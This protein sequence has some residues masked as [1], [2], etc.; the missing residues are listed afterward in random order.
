M[1]LT[2]TPLAENNTDGKPVWIF[3]NMRGDALP[4]DANS[5]VNPYIASGQMYFNRQPGNA[6]YN[7]MRDY[8]YT[9]WAWNLSS[10]RHKYIIEWPTSDEVI[11]YYHKIVGG[12]EQLNDYSLNITGYVQPRWIEPIPSTIPAENIDLD[13]A[14]NT[15]TFIGPINM[16]EWSMNTWAVEDLIENWSMYGRLPRGIPYI[17]FEVVSDNTP[18]PVPVIVGPDLVKTGN[19]NSWNA[20]ASWALVGNIQDYEWDFGDGSLI[21]TDEEVNHIYTADGDY[22]ITLTVNDSEGNS[23]STTKMIKASTVIAPE[24]IITKPDGS[25]APAGAR[26]D[27]AVTL[28]GW[29]SF[30][31][32]GSITDWEWDFGDGSLPVSGTGHPQNTTHTYTTPGTYIVSLTLTDNATNIAT[33]TKDLRIAVNLSD[34]IAKF[35][36]P[37]MAVVNASVSL[38]AS[39]SLS[40]VGATITSYDWDFDDGGTATGVAT[41]H[42]WNTTGTHSATLTVT[43]DGSNVSTPVMAYIEIYSDADIGIGLSLETHALKPGE[44]TNLTITMVDMA[45][46]TL[47]TFAGVVDLSSAPS[48]GVTMPAT[49]TFI[50]AD[51][52]TKTLTGIIFANAGSYKITANYSGYEGYEFASVDNRTVEITVYDI[53]E[54]PLYSFWDDRGPS[55]N[56]DYRYEYAS[57]PYVHYYV[58]NTAKPLQRELYTTYR[59]GLDARN[60]PEISINNPTFLPNFAYYSPFIT[61]ISGITGGNATYDLYW[62]YLA[63]DRWEQLRTDGWVSSSSTNNDGWWCMSWSNLTMDRDAAARLMGIPLAWSQSDI[64]DWWDPAIG[65]YAGQYDVQDAWELYWWANETGT[66]TTP[67]RLDYSAMYDAIRIVDT[68]HDGS[69]AQAPY[70]LSVTGGGTQVVLS[71]FKASWGEDALLIRQ[72]YYGGENYGDVYPDGPLMGVLPTEGWLEDFHMTVDMRPTDA[73]VMLDTGIVYGWRA[74]E[75]ADA[76]TGTASWRWE[77]IE[78]DYLISNGATILESELDPY[79]TPTILTY[80]SLDCGSKAYGGEEVTYDFVPGIWIMEQGESLVIEAPDGVVIGYLPSELLGYDATH[81]FE[82]LDVIEKWGYAT[83]HASGL[84]SDEYTVDAASGDLKIVGPFTPPI[85]PHP[86]NPAVAMNPA[87]LIEIWV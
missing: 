42:T 48:A 82:T 7:T 30:D 28:G 8:D 9:P 61:E 60:I 5:M 14:N 13:F 56:Q 66:T 39:N 33:G 75:S 19:S 6:F 3:E 34:P 26:V 67:G 55:Y 64:E 36:M 70:Q 31:L 41:S 38:D 49:A 35:V 27:D 24:I 40:L 32:D 11:G 37:Q 59:I 80:A 73:D 87:P 71:M 81:Y 16:Y 20:S 50:V 72:M 86:D 53:F 17:E 62:Q 43:D 78:A 15:L 77:V 52:G 2:Y 45:G 74:Y 65:P 10:D 84:S 83:L 44:S 1:D 46:N 29:K 79:Y 23:K 4:D 25:L 58:T 12:V 76:P 22:T 57:A 63:S 69:G 51:G 68:M 85:V 54:Y 18:Y 47:T 21:E